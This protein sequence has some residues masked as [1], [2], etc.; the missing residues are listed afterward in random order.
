MCSSD[1]TT[2][3]TVSPDGTAA[4][5]AAGAVVV[6]E[7]VASLR[8]FVDEG[9]FGAAEVH[10]AARVAA[11]SGCDDAYVLLAVAA[12][13]WA[14]RA[15]HS[16]ADL[17]VLPDVVTASLVVARSGDDG[18]ADSDRPVLEWPATSTW[19]DAMQRAEVADVVRVVDTWDTSPHLDSRPLVVHGRRVYLQRHW[20]DEC[21][22]A[23]S[24]RARAVPMTSA[25]TDRAQQVL[26][27]LLPAIVEG[28]HNLQRAAEFGRAH[29]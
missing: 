29:V 6:P 14:A 2:T 22:V 10:L 15:G 17:D 25:L 13:T 1:L 16:C 23:A 12:A 8:P 28:E 9:V 3:P 24:L 5:A 27:A 4:V 20:V 21:T 7:V 18:E 26:D 11:L 19:I